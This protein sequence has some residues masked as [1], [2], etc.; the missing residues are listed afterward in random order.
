MLRLSIHIVVSC[1]ASMLITACGLAEY[2]RTIAAQKAAY[3][4]NFK[5]EQERSAI[6][7]NRPKSQAISW[8]PINTGLQ[9]KR[10]FARR[11]AVLFSLAINPLDPNTLFGGAEYQGAF[12]STD[13]DSVVDSSEL[14]RGNPLALVTIIGS[15]P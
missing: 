2:Q 13:G 1:V 7:T 14:T 9:G 11:E 6:L 15:H 8:S 10:M 4:W 12:K 3:E 5:D